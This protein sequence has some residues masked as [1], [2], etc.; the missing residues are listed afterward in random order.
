MKRWINDVW[1]ASWAFCWHLSSIE[2]ILFWRLNWG[3]YKSMPEPW[4]GTNSQP[5][6]RLRSRPTS[7]WGGARGQVDFYT[8]TFF[9]K[10][11]D[12]KK[13]WFSGHWTSYTSASSTFNHFVVAHKMTLQER[14]LDLVPPWREH[15]SKHSRK[16]RMLQDQSESPPARRMLRCFCWTNIHKPLDKTISLPLFQHKSSKVII[17]H[18]LNLRTQKYR[19]ISICG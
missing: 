3:I 9:V 5:W 16:L 13:S 1:C 19:S 2:W 6:R 10:F 12:E 17:N 15:T 14:K 8:D 4:A 7:I 11:I 18:A